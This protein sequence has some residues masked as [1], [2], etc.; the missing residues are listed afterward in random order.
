[1]AAAYSQLLIERQGPVARVTLNRP[2]VRNAMDETTFDEIIRLFKEL[3]ED[4]GVRIAVIAGAGRD[5]CAGGDINWMK[6]AAGYNRAKNKKDAA[7]LANMC[8]AI[9]EAPFAVIGRVHGNC[10]GGG[11]GIVAACDVVIAESNSRFSFSEGRLGLIPSVVSTFV[12]PKVNLGQMRRLYITAE[13][14]S[15]AQA[16]EAG[17]VHTVAP[18]ENLES[19]VETAI[20][21]ILKT[22]PQT[23]RL[24]KDYLRRF[25][26]LKRAQRFN[27]CIDT[28]ARVRATPQAKEGFAAF[29][30]KRKPNWQ[31]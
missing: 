2:D 17:L 21:D 4:E 1:M 23:A 12:A 3:G 16:K 10:F 14:F 24:V 13:I 19:A 29:L 7:R 30:D 15:A 6:R 18:L 11:L 27:Y 26:D 8:R 9:D 5:F 22:A 28:L 31:R 25:A 20:A